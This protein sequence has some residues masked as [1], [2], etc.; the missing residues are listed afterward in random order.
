MVS[1]P[2]TILREPMIVTCPSCTSKYRLSDDKIQ[3]RG[4]RITCPTC[5]HRFVVYRNEEAPDPAPP[6]SL[7]SAGTV[8]LNRGVPVTIARQGQVLRAQVPTDPEEE[9]PTTLMP[10]G[11]GLLDG[12]K[13]SSMP[14]ADE[15]DPEYG[16][17]APSSAAPAAA[18]ARGSAANSR[19]AQY[20]VVVVLGTAL[21]VFLISSGFLG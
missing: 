5:T 15:E 20:L 18:A 3:G 13:R 7:A 1:S 4:A 19:F 11:S 9:A 10:H 17:V 12:T 16:A 14:A 6:S 2:A 8:N 21:L